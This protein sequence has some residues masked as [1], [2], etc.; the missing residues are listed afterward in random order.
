[1]P[2]KVKTY[3]AIVAFFFLQPSLA[4][5]VKIE[6]VELQGNNVVIHYNL[7]D[8]NTDRK[9]SLH[10]YT[11]R[12]NYVQPMEMVDGD[13]GVDISVGE[14]KKVIWNVNKE[15]G[16]DFQGDLAIELKGTIY[17]PF[18]S[19][20]GFE[21]YEV[22]KRGKP[23]DFTW[24]GGRGDNV[25]NFELYRGETKVKVFEE[26]PNVGN[27][28]LTIPTDVKPGKGYWF[29]ISDKRNRDEVVHTGTFVVQ[30]KLPLILK[31]G[32]GAI[33]VGVT[34]YLLGSDNSQEEPDIPEPPLP[35]RE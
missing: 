13:I 5:E 4:Q 28:Q 21:Q 25:L 12:D 14:N 31:V 20:D 15:F 1:M 29:K 32:L 33:V 26:R 7:L 34:G 2:A 9:Y 22:L 8:Q 3:F 35:Q 23:Y 24:S 6:K 30:R 19:L 17:I 18:V 16:E 10:L 27:T 11:S